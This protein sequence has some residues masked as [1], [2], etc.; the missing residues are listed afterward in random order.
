MPYSC[1]VDMMTF[2][3]DTPAPAT[4]ILIS[5]DRDFVYPV[6]IL[7]NRRYRVILIAPISTHSSL[8]HQA[9][10][11]LDWEEVVGKHATTRPSFG[12]VD[13]NLADVR[14]ELRR[15][16]AWNDPPTTPSTRSTR[17]GRANSLRDGQTQSKKQFGH[18]HSISV[19]FVDDSDS[20]VDA[21]GLQSHN[22]TSS[23]LSVSSVSNSPIVPPSVIS[24][25]L[26]PAINEPL[27]DINS[28]VSRVPHSE[29]QS[30]HVGI[31]SDTIS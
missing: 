4:I 12:S 17:R 27:P 30:S 1:L 31:C 28:I 14:N 8:K 3:M 16:I 21:L 25:L 5:G 26:H 2:A 15:S 10:K 9:S 6:S 18:G 20:A 19:D 29:S 22:R 24:E 23:T 13:S 11:V 7:R